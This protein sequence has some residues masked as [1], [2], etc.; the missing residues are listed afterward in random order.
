MND[1]EQGGQ[2]LE[3]TGPEYLIRRLREGLGEYRVITG[4][5]TLRVLV[6]NDRRIDFDLLRDA[7]KGLSTQ[8][9]TVPPLNVVAP[10]GLY[11][12][13]NG[14]SSVNLH[15][16]RCMGCRTAEGRSTAIVYKKNPVS[17]VLSAPSLKGD[18][19]RNGLI[20]A[21]KEASAEALELAAQYDS[22]IVALESL[23]TLDRTLAT[24]RATMAEHQATL[25][26][27]LAAAATEKVE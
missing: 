14:P 9:I 10:C 23:P 24:V 19:T 7:Q 27:F 26:Y 20:A 22:A 12:V 3:I 15:R 1:T 18:L 16:G 5:T 13:D 21:M 8:Q 25:K 11:V 2:W 4:G 6:P 17:T